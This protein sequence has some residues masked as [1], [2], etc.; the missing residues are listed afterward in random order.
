MLDK[1]NKEA[2]RQ[3]DLEQMYM[4][5]RKKTL[6]KNRFFGEDEPNLCSTMT[7]Y[8]RLHEKGWRRIQPWSVSQT[9]FTGMASMR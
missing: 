4:I 7:E 2:G 5:P 3:Q 9:G 8:M 1:A 6:L